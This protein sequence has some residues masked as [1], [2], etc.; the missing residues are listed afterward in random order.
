MQL[1]KKRTPFTI[2]AEFA[3]ETLA[4]LSIVVFAIW[5]TGCSSIHVDR[6]AGTVTAS[7]LGKAKAEHCV[8]ESESGNAMDS[9]QTSERA[10]RQQGI[11]EQCT[12]AEGGSLSGNFVDIVLYGVTFGYF[13]VSPF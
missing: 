2:L 7:A 11:Y 3:A 6:D 5:I 4:I 1:F 13:G 8:R 12:S 9:R 10:V